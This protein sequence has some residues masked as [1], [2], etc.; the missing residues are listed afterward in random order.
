[1]QKQ[2]TRHWVVRKKWNHQFDKGIYL[3]KGKKKNPSNSLT[4][5]WSG[6]N[7][8][9]DDIKQQMLFNIS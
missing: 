2:E 1:M 4:K 5:I 6:T 9:K 8:L 7:N 3:L